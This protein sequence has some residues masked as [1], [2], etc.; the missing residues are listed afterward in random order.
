MAD[1]LDL[2]PA[3]TDQLILVDAL[4]R[5]RGLASKEE[6]HR[7]ALL[8]RALSVVLAREGE[9]GLEVL[10][11]QRADGKYHSAGLWANS[12]CSHPRAGEDTAE[13][14]RRRVGEELGCGVAGLT[15][16]GAFCYRATF[17]SGITEFEYDHVFVGTPEGAITP[18][19][20]E[21][22]QTRWV[23]SDD[24]ATELTLHPEAFSAW[25]PMVL[26][27]A[28]AWLARHRQGHATT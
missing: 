17:E 7:D 27:L 28:L 6:A 24:V 3:R 20:Y 2:D 8:H 18:D 12:V 22:S 23:T 5:P 4:D 11:S 10:L 14:A 25:A 19:P 1:L 26:S 16:I 9:R 13:A 21:V 15:E